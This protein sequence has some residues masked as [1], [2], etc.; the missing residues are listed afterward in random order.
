[1][2]SADWPPEHF[3]ALREL[4]AKG[5]SMLALVYGFASEG[6]LAGVRRR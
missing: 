5:T 3:P 1:M 4:H 2:Q 6:V